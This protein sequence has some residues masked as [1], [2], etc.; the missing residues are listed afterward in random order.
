MYWFSHGPLYRHYWDHHPIG[1]LWWEVHHVLGSHQCWVVA[2]SSQWG[3]LFHSLFCQQS[4][5]IV[6]VRSGHTQW[7]YYHPRVYY[8]HST[9]SMPQ[10]FWVLE[11]VLYSSHH[12]GFTE[13]RPL[14]YCDAWV[15]ASRNDFLWAR[16][17]RW[18][19]VFP[20]SSRGSS[21][22]YFCQP[23][24]IIPYQVHGGICL[25]TKQARHIWLAREG[26][27]LVFVCWWVFMG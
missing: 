7:F 2:L 5:E 6:W 9:F 13:R 21:W 25:E 12:S 18:L 16:V 1:C 27:V 19:W 24:V 11:Q 20:Y 15:L 17:V 10:C 4:E 22:H 23:M 3:Y 26:E 8:F 14:H